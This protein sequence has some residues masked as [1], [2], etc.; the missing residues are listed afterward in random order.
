MKIAVIGAK[1]LPPKQGGIEHHCAEICSR[2]VNRGHSVDLFARS[3]WTHL[4]AFHCH[5]FRG[6]RVMSLPCF[7]L[8]STDAFISAALGAL[9]SLGDRY[10]IVHFHSLGPALFSGLPHVFSSAKVVVTCHGLDWQR[11][12]WSKLASG[13][14]WLGEKV[15]VN[16]ADEIV[17][18][19]D[20]LQPYFWKTYGRN[21]AYIPNAPATYNTS[22]PDFTYVTTTLGLE[23]GRYIVF[24]GR[25]VPEKCPDLLIQAF[26]QL[27]PLG[28]KLVV[29]GDHDA[30]S[31]KAKLL[32]LAAG[33]PNV[34]FTGE[35]RGRYLA[36]VV[37][38]AGLS[39]LPSN[40]EGLPLAVLEAMHEGIPVLASNIPPHCQLLGSDRGLLFRTEDLE[41]CIEQLN[42]AIQHPQQMRDMAQKAQ[43]YV[44]MLYN[45]DDI[46]NDYLSLYERL[47]NLPQQLVVKSKTSVN[48]N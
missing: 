4:P 5:D 42:W 21:V 11:A 44:K 47:L 26:K 24:L 35:L 22:D 43:A 34:I 33:D 7:S 9:L 48:W 15:A 31:F 6:V 14:I 23:L 27:Q 41:S 10:D 29:V 19:S 25:L 3:S 32:D 13:L 12:K 2:L 36:E 30:P 18:V 46:T 39:V 20:I 1:G 38:G 45:W 8:R 37:R 17:V 40:L 28:W 16:V